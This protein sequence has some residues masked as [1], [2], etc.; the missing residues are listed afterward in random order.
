MAFSNDQDDIQND[1]MARIEALRGATCVKIMGK[2]V[3]Q[4]VKRVDEAKENKNL[5]K[6]GPLLV[7]Q[8]QGCN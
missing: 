8:F 4:V 5:G 1:N 6:P 2:G 7:F 3:I